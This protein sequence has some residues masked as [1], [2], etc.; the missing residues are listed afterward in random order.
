MIRVIAFMSVRWVDAH[1]QS[2]P[3]TE[4]ART[5]FLADCAVCHGSHGE[6]SANGPSLEGVG[7]ASIDYWVS[8]GRMPLSQHHHGTR[9]ERQNPKSS[10]AEVDALVAYVAQ[11]T[12][13][14]PPLPHVAA[15]GDAA[16]G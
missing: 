3:S 6:G 12:G 14:V 11:L 2:P 10:P 15:G 5:T 9:I 7:A 4:R 16:A 13:G 8:T 1:E